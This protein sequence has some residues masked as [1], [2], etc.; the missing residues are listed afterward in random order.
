[1]QQIEENQSHLIPV[2]IVGISRSWFEYIYN[3]E[4]PDK[5]AYRCRLCHKYYDSFGLENRYKPDLAKEEGT[6]KKDKKENRKTL[7]DHA[8]LQSHLK[9][10]EILQQRS[11]KR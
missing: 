7:V 4:Y 2:D 11:S 3:A 5:S 8:K 1:M 10:V 9:V 6:L